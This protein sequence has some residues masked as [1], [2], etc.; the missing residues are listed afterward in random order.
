[1]VGVSEVVLWLVLVGIRRQ[2][3]MQDTPLQSAEE[4]R[5]K[6]RDTGDNAD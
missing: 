3:H 6:P 1:L 2:E 4:Q 5:T